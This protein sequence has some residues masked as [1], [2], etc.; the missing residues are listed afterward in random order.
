M[1]ARALGVAG[2]A[3]LAGACA[4]APRSALPVEQP[5]H[6]L[7]QEWADYLAAQWPGDAPAARLREAHR[8][9]AQVG[10]GVCDSTYTRTLFDGRKIM[11]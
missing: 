9:A 2:L 10:G 11:C 5:S 8:L 7:V 6:P 3:L 1:R 4:V